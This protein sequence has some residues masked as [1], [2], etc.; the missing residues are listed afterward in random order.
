MR[1]FMQRFGDSIPFRISMQLLAVDCAT[2]VAIVIIA[3]SGTSPF[4]LSMAAIGLTAVTSFLSGL[5]QKIIDEVREL[6]GEKFV[7]VVQLFLNDA[8]N[9][10]GICSAIVQLRE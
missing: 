7:P 8:R 4:M 1:V 2:T 3:D 9:H 5:D 6:M 10:F